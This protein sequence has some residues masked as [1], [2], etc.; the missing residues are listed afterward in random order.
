MSYPKVGFP[1][2]CI[3][4]IYTKPYTPH[5][6]TPSYIG[7][8]SKYYSCFSSSLPD[9]FLRLKDWCHFVNVANTYLG[10]LT[11]RGFPRMNKTCFNKRQKYYS[12]IISAK[13]FNDATKL[14]NNFL[15]N[16]V[17]ILRGFT[18]FSFKQI[19]KVSAFYIEKQ[20]RFY[21]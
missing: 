5:Y 13:L 4:R 11:C 7:R 1:H 6:A 16:W 21:F 14:K 15:A 20:K 8:R 19:L 17:E 18:K 10:I 9:C 12:N 3:G 2:G